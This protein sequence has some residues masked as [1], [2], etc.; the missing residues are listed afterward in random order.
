MFRNKQGNKQSQQ[1]WTGSKEEGGA[2]DDGILRK[3]KRI[4][5]FAKPSLFITR[6]CLS[7]SSN[8]LLWIISQW[9]LSFFI[10]ATV[11][12]K[13]PFQGEKKQSHSQRKILGDNSWPKKQPK[14][15][16]KTNTC[17]NILS[18]YSIKSEHILWTFT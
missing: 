4:R 13:F 14:D 10:K 8:W 12:K 2:R 6:N 1:Y 17:K 7:F 15:F 9:L 3:E 5:I 16:L 18:F 11:R